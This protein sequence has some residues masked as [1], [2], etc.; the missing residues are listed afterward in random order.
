M[1]VS[2]KSFLSIISLSAIIVCCLSYNSFAQSNDDCLMCHDDKELQGSK[3]GKTISLYANPKT[4]L[5]SIH[6][7]NNCI[8][9]HQNYNPEEFPH[10]ENNNKA[11]CSTLS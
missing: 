7:S 8:D 3:N 11:Q 1:N 4:L 6:K 2:Y 9:C 5:A 10:N